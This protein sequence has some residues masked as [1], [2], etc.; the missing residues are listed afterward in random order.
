M[1]YQALYAQKLCTPDEAVKIVK[2]G[3][4]VDYS[5]T[6]S[7]PQALDAALARR[8]G[9]LHDVKLR[10]AI[11]MIPVQTVEND[12]WTANT[13]IRDVLIICRC[14]SAMT[15]RITAKAMRRSMLP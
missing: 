9:E 8:S 5:Q 3:D 6:C 10:N 13:S 15:A 14:C 12:P 7:F 2:D 11:S 4:W 1:D